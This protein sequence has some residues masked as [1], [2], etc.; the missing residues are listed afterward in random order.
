MLMTIIKK[1][2]TSSLKLIIS[3]MIVISCNKS[4]ANDYSMYKTLDHYGFSTLGQK[5]SL[6]NIMQYAGILKENQSFENLYPFRTNYLDLLK[7]M[8]SFVKQTQEHFTKRTG[9]K[10][11]WEI[12]T[13][14]WIEQNKDK[15][16]EDAKKLGFVDEIKN[17]MNEVDAVCIL[18][19]TLNSMQNRINYIAESINSKKLM[20]KNLILL[21]GERQV[22]I[23]VDGD[24]QS[25]L[26]IAKKYNINDLS[27][28]TETHLIQTAYEESAI[29]NQLPTFVIDT[30]A[31]KLPR[32][33]TETTILELVKWLD[34]HKDIKT[35]VFISNQPYVKYQKAV[36]SQIL[37]SYPHI[38][39]EVVGSKASDGNPLKLIEGLG[40]YIWAKTPEI[41]LQL[42]KAIPNEK[43]L[44]E[45]KAVYGKNILIYSDIKK[46]FN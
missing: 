44:K 8:L 11:R 2:I 1:S 26:L 12:K 6:E 34:S 41:I 19:S 14:G 9:A 15:I 30:P 21:A 17:T 35:I 46:I 20:A 36:I 45:F 24:E 22:T 37:K 29:Y 25:L 23:T 42:G 3:L 33:T 32:P 18:G 4:F 28:L 16:I 5:K 43:I 7:D 27:K 31:G 39:F 38:T 10:E 13:S 40:S